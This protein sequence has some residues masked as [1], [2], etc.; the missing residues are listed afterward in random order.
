[1]RR[2]EIDNLRWLCILLLFPYHAAM[3]YNCWGEGFYV[4][5]VSSEAISSFI[6]ATYTWFMPLL[7]VLAGASSAFALQKRT[8]KEYA[9][10]RVKKLLI[11]L[12]L[13]ILFIVPAQTYFAER[14]HNGY[15]G[16]YFAQYAL[17]FG[18][19]GDL[20]GYTGGFTV[21]HLWFLLYL[22]VISMLALPIMR[23][24]QRIS[25]KLKLDALPVYAVVLLF[26]LPLLFAPV[27]E[28]GGKSMG[29]YFMLFLVG[30]FLLAN[31]QIAER[32]EQSRIPLFAAAVVLITVKL[33]LYFALNIRDGLPSDLFDGLVMAVCIVGFYAMARRHLNQSTQ[34]TQWLS[35][36]SFP[37][38]ILHQSVLIAVAYYVV[39]NVSSIAAQFGLITVISLILTV[40]LYLV[41]KRIPYARM[42]IGLYEP[43][44]NQKPPV[45]RTVSEE[46]PR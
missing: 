46:R 34:L 5:G 16:G 36:A 19:F 38:Y 18:K 32:L 35:R 31:E 21:G 7:F 26:F 13:G 30:Y 44:R 23:L 22:F 8:T 9:L 2:N 20:S 10:E 4:R 29:L 27:F 14:F 6:I 43:P 3:V 17:F 25:G 40:A 33:T 39:T 11:P 1:M 45:P 12:L 41:L 37:L 15:T 42:L 24:S 28:I